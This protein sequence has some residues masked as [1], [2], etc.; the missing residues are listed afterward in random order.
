M[1]SS[2]MK[3]WQKAFHVDYLVRGISMSPSNLD[4]AF[5]G[6]AD[7]F[8]A[9]EVF[10]DRDT[11]WAAVVESVRNVW[12]TVSAP[13]FDVQDLESPRRNVLVF[14]GVGGIGKTTLS[15]Q[16]GRRLGGDDVAMS[17][18]EVPDPPLPQTVPVYLD[19]ADGTTFELAEVILAIRLALASRGHRAPAFDLALSRYWEVNRPGES[20]DD[21]LRA[22][23][24]LSRISSTL[25]EQVNELLGEVADT[26]ELPGMVGGLV[27]QSVSALVK[28]LRERHDH[29][30]AIR[31][32][33]LPTIL[34]EEPDL[35]ALSFYPHLLAW[36][37]AQLPP[38]QALLPVVLLDTFEDVAERGSRKNERLINR[39]VWLMPNVLFVVTGRNRLRWD[40]DRLREKLW[41][42]GAV[43]WPL[44]RSDTGEPRQHLV[45]YLS[46]H[47][48]DTFL[49]Q[50]LTRDG[51]PMIPRTH[52][53]VIADRS[54]GLPLYLDMA[55]SL[56]V[57]LQHSDGAIPPVEA[58]DRDFS[59]LVT[60]TFRDLTL[61]EQSV[62]RAVSLL[63]SF[64]IELA[65]AA[66]GLARDS[67]ALCV[68]DR[69]FVEH[70]DSTLG[71]YRLHK[72]V[73]S[74]IRNADFDEDSR[75][76]WSESDWRRAA[77]R[78]F[79]AIGEQWRRAHDD[80]LV[81]VACLR[82]GLRLARDFSLRLGWLEDAA[83]AFVR[84]SAVE[85]ID[86]GDAPRAQDGT[87][88]PV[89][90][91]AVAL[92]L[93][94]SVIARRNSSH[95]Q[96]I[97]D[98]LRAVLTT[99][100][101]PAPMREIPEYYIAM[102]ERDLGNFDAS[103]RGMRKVADRGGRLA[104]DARRGLHHLLRRLGR[105][106]NALEI[107]EQLGATGRQ[108]RALGELWWSQ[109]NI[110]LACTSLAVAR[111]Q[112]T[113]AG[114]SGEAALCQSYLAFAAA[115]QD[116]ARAN[117]QVEHARELIAAARVGWAEVLLQVAALVVDAGHDPDLPQRADE[118]AISA[119]AVGLTSLAGYARLA[120][121]FHAAVLDS[122]QLSDH[123]RILL[124]EGVRGAE[125][126]Y[127][128]EIAYMF[129]D[130]DSPSTLRSDWIE[131]EST[132]KQRWSGLVTDRRAELAAT[133]RN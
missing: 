4:S 79:D 95:R 41:R 48:R 30:L 32:R 46:P 109:G 9:N 82:E 5:R 64:S 119:A 26:F 108:Q 88:L 42:T 56:F 39:L 62:V 114:L 129:T 44:L 19:L 106:R 33:R 31:C 132:A 34:E 27:S 3:H 111:D 7:D 28:A 71:P 128:V 124:R 96:T 103:M 92:A 112:S 123:A 89:D 101:L 29:A 97:V 118:I 22:R 87:P 60:A 116:R 49:A 104:P 45:G 115:F 72:L 83:V 6:N 52:R 81:L 80:R 130:R 37:I 36:D 58:F 113:A 38:K 14:Y 73:R 54:E 8:Q 21:Y 133:G 67:A 90:P 102:C 17:H 16:I 61:D 125:F 86:I 57:E 122:P 70:D 69:P 13:T 15:Q 120:A 53:Q 66:A 12:E 20:L 40:D 50:R 25:P 126:A 91:A 105:F 78:A 47:D 18:W 100:D 127:L 94:L 76:P 55:V 121:C 93:T 84:D 1:T 85:T 11:E 35:E 99:G 117:I 10:S 68:V 98:E 51:R 75:D 77:Q 65:T 24:R 23:T 131:G 59:G 110:A 63:E 107:A 2:G 74:A 43:R